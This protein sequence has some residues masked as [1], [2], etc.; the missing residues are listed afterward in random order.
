MELLQF[1]RSR[2]GG[3][4][5]G[6]VILALGI[7]LSLAL[8]T[9][10]PDDSSAFYTSTNTAVANW[11]GYYGA[12]IAWLFVSFL[13]FAGV[14]FPAALLI[15][16]WNRFW[17]KELEFLQTK[18][19]GFA[20][21][22]L[23]APPLL[24]LTLGKVWLRGALLPSG[25]YLGSE[26]HRA[27]AANLNGA[28]A[29]IVLITIALIGVLLATRISLAAIFLA[30]HEQLV[31]LGRAITLQWA[32]FT[33]RRRKEKMKEAIVR[34]HL[35]RDAPVLRLVEP[36]ADEVTGPVVREVRGAGRFQIRK[37]TK[38]DLRKAAEELSKQETPD[39]A[40][41]YPGVAPGPGVAAGFSR[42]EESKRLT[43]SRLKPAPTPEPELEPDDFL[44]LDEPPV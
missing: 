31:A 27:A 44:D 7:C 14:L 9:Y 10:H 34:K 33:E 1:A 38:A 43:E 12:T 32:R 8:L 18:L 3:E 22:V 24:D 23:T 6:I 4:L 37:V 40:T 21:L 42:P 28:G 29:A 39:P 35:E 11:I 19:I 13:G 2:R 15:L 41:L 30:L 16:G 20:L 26:I 5:I 36:P 25:G 17:G